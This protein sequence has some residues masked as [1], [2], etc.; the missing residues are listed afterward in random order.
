MGK[1]EKAERSGLD[2]VWGAGPIGQEIDRSTRQAFHLL[3]TG[4]IPS[5]KKIGGRWVVDR[6]TLRALFLEAGPPRGIAL[7]AEPDHSTR[8]TLSLAGDCE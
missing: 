2:L 8:A 4:A 7:K 6:G 1:S 5:A 3:S